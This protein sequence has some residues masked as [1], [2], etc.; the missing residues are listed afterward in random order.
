MFDISFTIKGW[1]QLWNTTLLGL[2]VSRGQKRVGLCYFFKLL[3]VSAYRSLLWAFFPAIK[4]KKK[5]KIKND[6]HKNIEKRFQLERFE[7]PSLA[8]L[9][10]FIFF[11]TA[12]CLVQFVILHKGCCYFFGWFLLWV[13]Y[14][15]VALLLVMFGFLGFSFFFFFLQGLFVQP[16]T[17]R[18]CIFLSS[19]SCTSYAWSHN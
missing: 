9:S 13:S 11:L 14:C 12:L 7:S 19:C 4:L 15:P 18:H 5:L 8:V 16:A 10:S 17:S 1:G 2:S 3:S 6:I